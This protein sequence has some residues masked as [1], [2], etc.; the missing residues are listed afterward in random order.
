LN[1]GLTIDA[2]FCIHSSA[3]LT[4]FAV[5]GNSLR[6]EIGSPVVTLMTWPPILTG[7]PTPRCSQ[8]VWSFSHPGCNPAAIANSSRA[9]CNV[10][11]LP[12]L[13][14]STL[15]WY[16]MLRAVNV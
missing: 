1:T 15:A 2:T 8:V 11:T 5:I 14:S 9:F 6:S 4:G 16:G 3:C 13:V 10:A 7:N 12:G